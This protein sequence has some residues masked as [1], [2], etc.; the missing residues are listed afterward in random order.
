[1]REASDYIATSH[2]I[3]VLGEIQF[4]RFINCSNMHIIRAS[5]PYSWKF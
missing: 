2:L 3:R 4:I 5:I 1:M